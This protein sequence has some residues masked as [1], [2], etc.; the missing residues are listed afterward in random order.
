MTEEQKQLIEKIKAERADKLA[1]KK[2]FEDKLQEL[3]RNSS[4]DNSFKPIFEKVLYEND[5]FKLTASYYVGSGF[6]VWFRNKTPKYSVYDVFGSFSY[7]NEWVSNIHKASSFIFV[8]P[9]KDDYSNLEEIIENLDV[10]LSKNFVLA[11][12]K[13]L[14]DYLSSQVILILSI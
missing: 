7:F 13:Y 11:R 10:S 8:T 14:F 2:I 1:N 6:T 3:N 9:L 12:Y 5:L 4:A